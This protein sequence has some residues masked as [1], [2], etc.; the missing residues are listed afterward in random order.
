M[1]IGSFMI[2]LH[3]KVVEKEGKE[4]VILTHEEFKAVSELLKN[5]EDLLD[6]RQAK[7]DEQD[8][9]TISLSDLKKDLLA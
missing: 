5:Y 6:L 7:I 8:E 4:F 2:E 3:P 9:A 1:R